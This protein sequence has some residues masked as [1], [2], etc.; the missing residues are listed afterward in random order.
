MTTLFNQFY[1]EK[2]KPEDPQCIA[3]GQPF[4]GMAGVEYCTT[5]CEEELR[6]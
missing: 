3:C 2:A 1:G 6:G 5:T 4:K